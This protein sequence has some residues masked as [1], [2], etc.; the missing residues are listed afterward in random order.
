[1]EDNKDPLKSDLF[2]DI[3]VTPAE[4]DAQITR[5]APHISPLGYRRKY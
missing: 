4:I 2:G 5:V 3:S 1:M